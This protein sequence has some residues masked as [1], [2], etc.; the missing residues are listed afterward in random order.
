MR[1]GRGE[2]E[3]KGL[4]KHRVGVDMCVSIGLWWPS[5]AL[6]FFYP[7]ASI[8]KHFYPRAFPVSL[9]AVPVSLLPH[10][11]FLSSRGSSFS[12]H[13][14]P[15]SILARFQFLSSH[16]SYPYAFPV[17]FLARFQFLSSHGSISI[18][19][20]FQFLSSRGIQGACYQC[21]IVYGSGC[22]EASKLVS[23]LSLR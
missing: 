16:G 5:S 14:V 23:R 2:I 21:A 12:P 8:L 19:E 17:S 6:E 13:A 20:R 7:P 9:L 1:K 4:E 3:V 10:F 11:Q 18:L 22:G 15:V